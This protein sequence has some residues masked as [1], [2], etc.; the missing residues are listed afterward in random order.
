M[1]SLI[2]PV[3]G[4]LSLIINLPC[5]VYDRLCCLSNSW[6]RHSRWWCNGLCQV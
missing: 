3:S 5:H 4:F 1:T 6:Q 2:Y